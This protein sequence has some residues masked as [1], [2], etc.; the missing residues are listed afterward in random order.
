MEGWGRLVDC[1]L[2]ANDRLAASGVRMR[3]A[4]TEPVTGAVPVCAPVLGSRHKEFQGLAS[5]MMYIDDADA[6]DLSMTV[7]GDVWRR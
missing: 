7:L 1:P 3:S 6:F 2:L 5:V 4:Y